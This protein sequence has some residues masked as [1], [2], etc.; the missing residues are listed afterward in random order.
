MVRQHRADNAKQPCHHPRN[1]A[2]E[3]LPA[4]HLSR[5]GTTILFRG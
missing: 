2:V 5:D 1:Q 3:P 4:P